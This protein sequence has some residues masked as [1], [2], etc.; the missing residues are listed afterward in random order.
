MTLPNIASNAS[1]GLE[2]SATLLSAGAVQ[3][4]LAANGSTAN[5]CSFGETY[6]TAVRGGPFIGVNADIPSA[7]LYVRLLSV[8]VV[9]T[10]GSLCTA[11]HATTVLPTL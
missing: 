6:R 1:H 2:G 5:Q 8:L 7:S 10:I 3:P 11:I 9:C 4:V